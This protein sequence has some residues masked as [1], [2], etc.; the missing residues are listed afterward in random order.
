ACISPVDAGL[1]GRIDLKICN[2]SWY[3]LVGEHERESVNSALGELRADVMAQYEEAV[4]RAIVDYLLMDLRMRE[5]CRVSLVPV[6]RPAWGTKTYYGIEGTVGGPPAEWEVSVA[7]ALDSMQS[8]LRSLH[9]PFAALLS[10]Q[11]LWADS[12]AAVT[13]SDLA[14]DDETRRS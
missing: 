7:G 14:G 12:Y 4:R 3:G 10:L 9:V 5:R 8:P 1:L 2:C 11:R 13:L 6:V